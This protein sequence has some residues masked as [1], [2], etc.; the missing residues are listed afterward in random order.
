MT[1]KTSDALLDVR[2]ISN[3]AEST[4][5]RLG[6]NSDQWLEM[7]SGFESVSEHLQAVSRVYVKRTAIFIINYRS[8]TRKRV[9][10]SQRLFN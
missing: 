5:T 9:A 6:I 8:A 2:A 7:E 1:G 10:Q 3:H 4:L